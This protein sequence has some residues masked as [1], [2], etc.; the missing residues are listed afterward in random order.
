VESGV[1]GYE[2]VLVDNLSEGEWERWKRGVKGDTRVKIVLCIGFGSAT[3]SR[4]L[5]LKGRHDKE[6]LTKKE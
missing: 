5:D 2:Q 1:S 3:G 6:L 4:L